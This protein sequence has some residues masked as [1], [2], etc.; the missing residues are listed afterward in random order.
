M[1]KEELRNVQFYTEGKL[2]QTT[3]DVD[4]ARAI[5]TYKDTYNKIEH[6]EIVTRTVD[7]R[8]P[9]FIREEFLA[10]THKMTI[11]C[12]KEYL[13]NVPELLDGAQYQCGIRNT[14]SDK[15]EVF[16]GT[17]PMLYYKL[18]REHVK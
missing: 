2:V 15:F 9:G 12:F 10:R 5:G 4:T 6:F 3:T 18:F 16:S 8:Q 17:I 14:K 13:P 1:K 11:V 7:G